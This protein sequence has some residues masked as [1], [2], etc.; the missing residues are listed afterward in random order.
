V[1]DAITQIACDESGSEGENLT[2]SQHSIFVHAS[3]NLT[4]AEASAFMRELRGAVK[5]NA[6]E[7]KSSTVLK[8]HHRP[9]LLNAIGQSSVLTGRANIYLA[10][11]S[12]FVAG[13]MIDLLVE[14]EAHDHGIDLVTGGEVRHLAVVL[15]DR[16]PTALGE[17][18]WRS[19]LAS[20]NDLIRAYKRAG[21]VQP[22]AS[23]FI[24]E[25]DRV[26]RLG[27]DSLV[28]DVLEMIWR[29]KGQAAQYE[30]PPSTSLRNMEPM[31]PTLNAVAG[32]W[33]IRLGDV[34]FEF[35]ADEHW[36]LDPESMSFLLRVAKIPLPVSNGVEL[37]GADLRAIHTVDSK[38]DPRVQVADILAGVGR[39]AALLAVSGTL[40]DPLQTAIHEMYDFQ[41]M[42]SPGSPLESLTAIKPLQ[43]VNRFVEAERIR[44]GLA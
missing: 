3:V 9:A 42:W 19:L 5:S 13:K 2:N 16:A 28:H 34:P 23:V 8:E 10:D 38:K 17:E 25:L 29:A 35:V 39:E 27:S 31:V 12:F 26:R 22:S 1:S 37:P 41:G 15:Y 43:Y 6:A 32:T 14:E 7:L 20:F 30:L 36:A 4:V 18:N 24:A 40:D 11:K 33:R 44:L 21:S